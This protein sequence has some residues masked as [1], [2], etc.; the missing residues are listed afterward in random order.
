MRT[1]AGA[2]KVPKVGVVEEVAVG[3]LESSLL[4]LLFAFFLV[5]WVLA[6]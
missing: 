4:K 2:N 1:R 3:G 6:D 5:G